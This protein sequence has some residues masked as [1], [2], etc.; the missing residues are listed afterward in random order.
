MTLT[1]R[2]ITELD[3]LPRTFATLRVANVAA[4]ILLIPWRIYLEVK[5]DQHSPHL[6]GSG[7]QN[8]ALGPTDVLLV[9][10]IFACTPLFFGRMT[11]RPRLRQMPIG[12]IGAAVFAVVVA[13]WL[14][15]F[16]TLEGLM[17]LL[18]VTGVPAVIVAIRAM[19]Q[20]DLMAGVVWP[21][22]F[23][24][25]VQATV[26]LAQTHIYDTGMVVP[27]TRLAVGRGWTAGLG[28]FSGPYALAAYLLLGMA[29]ALSFGISKHPANRRFNSVELSRPL[30][31]MM[32]ITVVLTSA[33]MATTFGRAALLSIGL[34]VGVYFV[35]W[36]MHRQKILGLSALAA[37]VPLMGTGIV[38]RSGWIVRASQSVDFDFTTR[39]ALVARAVEMIR[40]SPLI[41][42]GPVQYGPNLAR[43]DLAVPDPHIVHNLPLLVAV[44]FGIVVGLAFTVWLVALGVRAFRLSIYAA[45]L[46]LSVLPLMLLDNLHYVY[47]NGIAMFAIWVAMLDYHRDVA[48]PPANRHAIAAA[49]DS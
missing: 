42:I 10:L 43:M 17:M 31:T 4:L 24:A 20:R 23:G 33:A 32:W 1:G 8:T 49:S 3:R 28:A 37:L 22:S 7:V 29:V 39:D 14:L 45:A 13:V 2:A 25:S 41:G 44:E 15:M 48:V 26:A 19:S 40:S 34:V 5:L 38:L 11:Q 35:G 18:R 30:E 46:F 9:F 21:L 47:G 12:Q 36:I 6:A 16:P 27:A